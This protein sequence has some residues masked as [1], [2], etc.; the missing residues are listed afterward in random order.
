[1]QTNINNLHENITKLINDNEIT[2]SKMFSY[3]NISQ[4]KEMSKS[5]IGL[6][7]DDFQA[8]FEFLDTRP[9]CE[10]IK[11]YMVKIKKA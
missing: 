8:A 4:N 5:T 1:M 3:E 7:A 9:H 6:E 11:F 2:K 10:N